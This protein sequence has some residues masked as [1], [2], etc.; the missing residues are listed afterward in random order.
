MQYCS[1]CAIRAL[2]ESGAAAKRLPFHLNGVRL[3]VVV[4]AEAG[5]EL[6]LGGRAHIRSR[7]DAERK[8]H[9][10]RESHDA[11]HGKPT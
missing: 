5:N 2:T 1:S 6:G 10:D 3:R 7:H 9:E 4:D 8:D 11:S